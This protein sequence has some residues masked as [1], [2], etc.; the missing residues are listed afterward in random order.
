MKMSAL[1]ERL[2]A[3]AVSLASGKGVAP[4]VPPRGAPQVLGEGGERSDG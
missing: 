4:R 3:V 2:L 1:V